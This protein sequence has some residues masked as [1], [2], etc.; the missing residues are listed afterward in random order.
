[1][2]RGRADEGQAVG[3]HHFG[4][5]GVLRQ[6]AVAGVDCIGAGDFGGRQD[7]GFL[8]VAFRRRRR[9]DAD[10]FVSQ[11]HR[12]RVAVSLGMDDHGH[13]SHFLART[14]DA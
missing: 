2:L 6:E 12:H 5:L 11:A 10:A 8:E 3:F 7:A 4:K 1:M 14:V 9:S 13:Q